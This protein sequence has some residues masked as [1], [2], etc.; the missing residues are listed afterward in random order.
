VITP[1]Q[2][3]CWKRK[4]GNV[5][6]KSRAISKHI[7]TFVKAVAVMKKKAAIR[8]EKQCATCFSLVYRSGRYAKGRKKYL[9]IN[10]HHDAIGKFGKS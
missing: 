10:G 4:H 9:K 6:G 3:R 2:T 8:R 7:V 5:E 1:K